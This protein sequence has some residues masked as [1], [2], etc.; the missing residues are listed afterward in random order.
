LFANR[1][2]QNLLTVDA[3]PTSTG[4]RAAVYL[5]VTLALLC[6]CVASSSQA[7]TLPPVEPYSPPP[8]VI[9]Q[10]PVSAHWTKICREK[11]SANMLL[12]CV[13]G[14]SSHIG[15][16]M[17]AAMLIAPSGQRT[18]GILR[19]SVPLGIALPSGTTVTVDHDWPMS[20]PYTLCLNSG[21]IADFE[22][23]PELIDRLKRGR[24]LEIQAISNKGQEITLSLPLVGFGKAYDRPPI[25]AKSK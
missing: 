22:A 6:T 8:P 9:A 12:S 1:E 3:G 17:F 7:T 2:N 11:S 23:G 14:E 4:S 19:V 21:C 24:S 10:H 18:E 13:T 16:S 5:G 25:D 15:R 20:A